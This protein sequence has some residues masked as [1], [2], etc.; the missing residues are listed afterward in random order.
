MG[1]NLILILGASVL[2]SGVDLTLFVL[3]VGEGKSIWTS[4][5]LVRMPFM[6]IVAL[7]YGHLAE[8]V[9]HE[10]RRALME[11]ELAQKE[12]QALR[13]IDLAITSTLELR[14]V[15][16]VLLEKIDLLLPYAVAT[17]RLLNKKTGELESV[18][19][20]N[21]DEAEWKTAT[22]RVTGG[23]GRMLPDS[24][25]PLVMRNAQTDPRSL[26]SE[27][28]RK[29]GLVSLL[30]V[31]LI[32]KG[33]PLGVLT[34][35]TKDEHEFSNQE[36]QFL[37]TLASQAAVAIHN[38]QLYSE[39][40]VSNRIKDEF[41]SVMSHELRT[42]LTAITGYTQILKEEMLAELNPEQ[43]KMLGKIMDRS[44]D[45]LVMINGILE[46]I[47]L[48]AQTVK[49][50]SR[51]VN[52]GIFLDELRSNYD[53]PMKKGLALNW[54]YPSNLPT[55]TT[56][57]EKLK[58]ILQN[59]INNAIK[60]TENGSVTVS[61]RHIPEARTVEFRVADTGVGIPEEAHPIIFEKF[62]QFDSS[63]TRHYGGTGLGLYIVKMFTELLGGTVKVDSEPGK[64][65]TFS[66]ALPCGS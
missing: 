9:K 45:L 23:L 8:K 64:G 29:H 40:A 44:K 62:R 59:L 17:V 10:Q 5:S 33:E 13:E 12:M 42:P 35:F 30:R 53:V 48:E 21:L 3:P 7:F 65:S 43:E 46:A 60:F 63:E 49:V 28:L 22:A 34:F 58:H 50:L 37:T 36:V 27:F 15:L 16:D 20:R 4:P 24:D 2:L 51:E 66:I 25:A 19:C 6:F 47:S 39:L 52:L 1:Q 38:S 54:D 11:E 56:D 61:A 32:A 26:D 55:V 57:G 18:A 41:L 14:A 31:P